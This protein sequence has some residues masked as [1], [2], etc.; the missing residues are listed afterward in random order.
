MDRDGY[1]PKSRPREHDVRAPLSASSLYVDAMS[2]IVLVVALALGASA[3]GAPARRTTTPS[4][5]SCV[6]MPLLAAGQE[7]GRPLHRMGPVRSDARSATEAERL[8]SLREAACA[9]GGDAVI[10]AVNEEVRLPD[11]TYGTIASGTAVV[12][13]GAAPRPDAPAAADEP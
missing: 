13:T 3:C 9:A 10:E 2:R 12:W 7:P 8:A 1:R 5:H 11:G 4:G 6:D